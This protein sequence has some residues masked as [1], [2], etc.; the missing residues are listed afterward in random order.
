[1]IQY[2]AA[3]ADA[4]KDGMGMLVQGLSGAFTPPTD[5]EAARRLDRLEK[6]Q[7]EIKE[8][9]KAAEEAVK[10]RHEELIKLLGRQDAS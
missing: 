5:T 4:M 1:M 9:Q 7:L 10:A 6:A 2:A 8:A 3:L